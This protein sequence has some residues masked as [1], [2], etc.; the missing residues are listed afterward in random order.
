MGT[1]MVVRT[2]SRITGEGMTKS[3]DGTKN[4]SK[5][6]RMVHFESPE[7]KRGVRP[8]VDEM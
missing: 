8:D 1:Y 3:G 6:A 5:R 4:T 7:P 2:K